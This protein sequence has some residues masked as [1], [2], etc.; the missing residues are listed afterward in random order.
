MGFG[1]KGLGPTNTHAAAWE[2]DVEKP[3][4]RQ[5]LLG[6]RQ[7]FKP[8]RGLFSVFVGIWAFRVLG[9]SVWGFGDLG[10]GFGVWGFG[11]RVSGLG[12]GAA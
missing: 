4:H 12:F 10:L 6:S 9:F 2:V 5:A 3:H 11:F 7:L 1:V 8:P